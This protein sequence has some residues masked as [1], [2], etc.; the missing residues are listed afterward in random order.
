VRANAADIAAAWRKALDRLSARSRPPDELLPQLAAA[1]QRTLARRG[2]A[3]RDHR[4]PLVEVRATDGSTRTV[5]DHDLDAANA[6]SSLLR[7]HAPTEDGDASAAPSAPVTPQEP[8]TASV[9][10]PEVL[11]TGKFISVQT[12]ATESGPNAVEVV[13][14]TGP[15]LT[16]VDRW[17]WVIL[18][19]AAALVIVKPGWSN[20]SAR[21]L[22]LTHRRDIWSST[23]TPSSPRRSWRR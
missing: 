3:R 1:C 12:L 20:S 2:A 7:T 8:P 11:T 9:A 23:V 15:R 21:P 14:V 6:N 16:A 5:R 18:R 4:V 19:W 13:D 17:F 22:E 10:D